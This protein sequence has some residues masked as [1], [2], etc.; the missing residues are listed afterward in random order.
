MTYSNNAISKPATDV[1]MAAITGP[2][3]ISFSKRRLISF[4]LF[5][6]LALLCP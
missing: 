4:F 5:F 3:T 1:M 6:L 2:K